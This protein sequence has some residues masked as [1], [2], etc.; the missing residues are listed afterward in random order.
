[1]ILCPTDPVLE[2]ESVAPRRPVTVKFGTRVT[3]WPLAA[4]WQVL[5]TEASDH[6]SSTVPLNVADPI[7]QPPKVRVIAFELHELKVELP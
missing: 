6:V 7:V 3:E 2:T 5:S 4:I 1:V